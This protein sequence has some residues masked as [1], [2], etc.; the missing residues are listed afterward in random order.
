M[1]NL[2]LN[3]AAESLAKPL[4]D[5]VKQCVEKTLEMEAFPFSAEV[6][7]SI[8]DNAGIRQLNH[9]QRG[10]DRETD[11]LSFPMLETEDGVLI[12]ADEDVIEDSVFLG[13]IVISL[14]KAEEQAIAYGHSLEREL[15]FLTV[16]AMLHLL[17][18]DH[19]EG[20]REETEMFQKQEAVLSA[21]KLFR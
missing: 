15:G 17:G 2:M 1:I 19:E 21:L 11:V 8:T 7:F 16:H 10:I 4:L 9:E 5:I 14:P 12:V 18:Y 13:D 3:D 6:S 20:P